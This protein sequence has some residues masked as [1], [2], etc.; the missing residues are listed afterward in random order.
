MKR[1]ILLKLGGK[2]FDQEAGYKWL[3]ST[4]QL[5]STIDYIIV[6][7]GGKE[8]NSALKRAKRPIQFINGLRVTPAEDMEIIEKV[9]SDLINKKIYNLLTQNGMR[10]S[11]LSGRTNH[12]L[13]VEPYSQSEVDLGYVGRVKR[14]NPE[15]V[16]SRLRMNHVPIIS[17]I[18]EDASGNAYNVNAD[19]A[20][21]A[22]AVSTQCTDL[23]YFTDVPGVKIEGEVFPHLNLKEVE[24]FIT[25]GIITDGM[26]PKLQSAIQAVK[27]Q[28]NRVYITQWQNE[29]ILLEYV[30][31]NYRYGT[32]VTYE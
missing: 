30:K 15:P 5:Q 11:R 24:Y 27:G 21:A 22:I 13:E 32:L 26:I 9:L 17:P 20:A 14:V 31:N 29:Y 12:L 2:A 28:V 7:G 25:S 4:L 1:R 18:S 16:L 6:H 8:I 19:E 3:A 23:I 10:C